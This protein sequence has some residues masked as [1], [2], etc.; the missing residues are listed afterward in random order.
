MKTLRYVLATPFGL[1]AAGL[2]LIV[3]A[4]M[5]VANLICGEKW[6]IVLGEG[7]AGQPTHDYDETWNVPFNHPR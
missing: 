3:A 5:H 2:C 7:D 4:L 1:V 6:D